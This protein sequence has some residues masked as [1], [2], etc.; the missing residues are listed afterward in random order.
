MQTMTVSATKARNNF[1]DILTWVSRGQTVMV[2]KDN[3]F[4][5]NIVPIASDISNKGLMKALN[6]ASLNF[7]YSKR[8]NPLRKKGSAQF[9]GKW[10]K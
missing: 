2:K 7:T 6:K 5:A 1:F 9:L 8:D 10:G 3:K 4:I